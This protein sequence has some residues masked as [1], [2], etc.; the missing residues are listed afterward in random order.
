VPQL[1]I[2]QVS[3]RRQSFKPRNEARCTACELAFA[4]DPHTSVACP[5]C[6]PNPDLLSPDSPVQTST[7]KRSCARRHT[8][9]PP[10]A[11]RVLRAWLNANRDH[12]YPSS[13]T[14]RALAEE[15]GITE[16]QV[17]T[18]FTNTRARKLPLLNDVSH[19]SS[20]DEG[21]YESDFSNITNTPSCT[22][23][24][25][26]RYDTPSSHP[27]DPSA[28]G[29]SN[30]VHPQ[31]A[32]QT[33]RRGKK[34]DYRRMN[35]VSPIDDSPVPRTPATPS[36]NP[37]GQRQETWPC[38]FCPQA[39]APKSWRRHE[40]TQHRPKHQW[41]CL[42]TG[43]RL[44][45]SSGLSICAFCQIKNPSED[46][47]LN[48]HRILECSKKSEADRTFGR[49]DHLRQH[50]KNFHKTSLL[51]LVRDKWRSLR[52]GHDGEQAWPCGFC[53]EQL[54]T[55]DARET[56]I[57][58]H[59]KDGK[60]MADWRD[61]T[62]NDTPA[63]DDD[64]RRKMLREEH[65]NTLTRLQES[66]AASSRTQSE[67][68]T[69]LDNRQPVTFDLLPSSTGGSNLAAVPALLNTNDDMDFPTYMS[70]TF[71]NS[72]DF[73]GPS[74][75]DDLDA[76]YPMPNDDYGYDIC[77]GD[78]DLPLEYA[79]NLDI[80]GNPIDFQNGWEHSQR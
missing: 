63:M 42:A 49:P 80:F 40:E 65:A 43:P 38:T 8:K 67:P 21:A 68:P 9:L 58:N 24:P 64:E 17:T 16:K 30:H 28:S 62:R 11:L 47:L 45:I 25:M 39:L 59:F 36:P 72:L 75:M 71:M 61:P 26:I 79:S 55:W 73:S 10:H 6:A 66:L 37:L 74:A 41:T 77:I 3:R 35:T 31:L 5:S 4:I 54:A 69:L 18:W 51:A 56:H 78:E 22:T 29:Q 19:G 14:K 50:I 20:G 12:P 44:R 76:L 60:T 15:C 23:S 53:E 13:D 48:S 32:L 27:Y 33:A 34:K 70:E 1:E 46:H 2:P 57:S 52:P 7:V